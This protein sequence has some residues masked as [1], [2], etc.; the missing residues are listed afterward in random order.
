VGQRRVST[1]PLLLRTHYGSGVRRRGPSTISP[2]SAV[3]TS[4][5]TT[6]APVEGSGADTG[7]LAH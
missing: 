6:S 4:P 7:R 5:L 1:P 3:L 2:P